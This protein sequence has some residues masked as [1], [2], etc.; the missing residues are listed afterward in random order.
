MARSARP[1]LFR[2]RHPRL[3]TFAELGKLWLERERAGKVKKITND[4]GCMSKLGALEVAAGERLA[5]RPIGRITEDDLER[6]FGTIKAGTANSTRNH[7]LQA[8]K[9]LQKWARRKGYLSA[10][11]LGEFTSLRRQKVA[12]RDR[13]LVPDQTAK[14]GTSCPAKRSASSPW[15]RRGPSG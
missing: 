6:A 4:A 14:D 2:R 7:Y 1:A 13:R 12:R 11:W 8:L 3:I 9:S 15:P 5:D 10:P